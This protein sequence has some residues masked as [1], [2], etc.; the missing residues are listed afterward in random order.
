ML[1]AAM[2][3][4]LLANRPEP[5]PPAP[6]VSVEFARD[7]RPILE[8]R[9]QPCHFTGGKMYEKLP[10]DRAATIDHLGTRLFT[11]IKDKQEQEIIRGYLSASARSQPSAPGQ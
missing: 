5:P 6:G 7:V 2:F 3:F 4:W 9:C 8:R 10:F 11:R 1:E